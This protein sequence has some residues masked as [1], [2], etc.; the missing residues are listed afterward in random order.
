M[1]GLSRLV[2]YG[3]C[4]AAVIGGAM[5]I[6]WHYIS[7]GK[8]ECQLSVNRAIAQQQSIAYQNADILSAKN[9]KIRTII[10][11]IPVVE[12]LNVPNSNSCDWPDST[13][14]LFNSAIDQINSSSNHEPKMP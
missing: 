4:L 12:K 2:I 6:R 8:Q 13:Q 14:R 1:F 5:A 7:L 3:I 10:K 9:V 11:R